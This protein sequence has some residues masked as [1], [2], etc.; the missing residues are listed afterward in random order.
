MVRGP[1]IQWSFCLLAETHFPL[2]ETGTDRVY[3]CAHDNNKGTTHDTHVTHNKCVLIIF[4]QRCEGRHLDD[5]GRGVRRGDD[6]RRE[7]RRRDCG[8]RGF[9]C[10][11][12]GRREGRRHDDGGRGVRRDKDWRR[13]GRRRDDGRR[14]GRRDNGVRRGDVAPV[15]RVADEEARAALR[16]M[17]R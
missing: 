6:G 14:G 11:D 13:E 10:G 12:D 7:G 15:A 9:S 16:P 8:G 4:V 1:L 5:G 3:D 17:R 2:T